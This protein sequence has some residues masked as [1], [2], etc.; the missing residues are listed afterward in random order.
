M[1][2]KR[3][4]KNLEL[5]ERERKTFLEFSKVFLCFVLVSGKVSVSETWISSLGN[6]RSSAKKFGPLK[7]SLNYKMFL[8]SF[9]IVQNRLSTCTLAQK[10]SQIVFA[11]AIVLKIWIS[12]ILDFCDT[13]KFTDFSLPLLLY[14]YTRK[15]YSFRC[16]TN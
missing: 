16:D 5:L 13:V 6:K 9:R 10:V 1:V 12:E 11:G 8:W 3:Q 14:G 2:L 15:F 7:C 4:S